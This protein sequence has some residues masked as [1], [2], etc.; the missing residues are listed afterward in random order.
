MSIFDLHR[1]AIEEYKNFIRS[2]VDVKDPRIKEYLRKKLEED[3]W[4]WPEP[5]LQV[6]SG[7]AYDKDVDGLARDGILSETTAR[8]FRNSR[9]EPFRLYRHQVEAIQ[10]ARQGRSFILTSG[11]GS[12]KSFAY[13]IPIF[14]Q[15]ARNP[16]LKGPVAIVVYPMN[17]LANSQLK[18][19]ETLKANYEA[20]YGPGSFPLSFALYTSA[21]SD[22]ERKRLQSDPPHLLLTNYVML[23]YLMVRP[24]D[25]PLVSPPEGGEPFFLVF[26][27]LHTYRGRQGAD[28]AILVRRL[29]ARFPEGRPLVHVGTS[30]TLV[31]DKK[32]GREERRRTVARFASDFFG[33]EIHGEDVVEEVLSPVTEGGPPGEDELRRSLQEPL[34]QSLS[35]WRKHPLAR[36]LEWELGLEE[37]DEGV[38]RRRTPRTIKEAAELLAERSGLPYDEVRKRLEEAIE[39]LCRLQDEGGR[40]VFAFKLHQ[41]ISQT[42]PIYATLEDPEDREFST[43]LFIRQERPLFPLRFCRNC[44]QEYY[45]ALFSPEGSQGGWLSPPLEETNVPNDEDEDERQIFYLAPARQDSEI[46]YPESW[47]D[48][49][50]KHGRE[51]R[52][53]K[54]TWRRKAPS[55]PGVGEREPVLRVWVSPSGR[56]SVD[57]SLETEEANAFF[58]Q[59]KPFSFCVSCGEYYEGKVSEYR[60]MTYLGSEGRASST[61]VLATALLKESRR[62]L[63]K[64]RSKLLSFTDNRQDASLQAGHF[65]D[66]A[67]SVLVRSALHRAVQKHG[68]LP[69]KQLVKE[70]LAELELSP[71]DYAKN[72]KVREDSPSLEKFKEALLSVL[73]LRLY[74]DLRHEWRFTQPNL[75]DLGLLEIEYFKNADYE[76]SLLEKFRA[77]F[78]RL[79]TLSD[80]AILKAARGFLDHLRKRLAIESKLLSPEGFKEARENSQEELNE[81]WAISE[82]EPFPR[83]GLLVLESAKGRNEKGAEPILL[84]QRSK[85][86]KLLMN[87]GL[88]PSEFPLFVE[89]LVE[90]D[91]LR[92]VGGGYRIPESSLFWKK[93]SASGGG[94]FFVDLYSSNTSDLKDLE[95]REHTAQ[96]S[97]EERLLRERRFR[98]TPEDVKALGKARRLPF[99]V[100]SPTLELGVDIADLD[101]V[102]LRN[103]PPT[104]ANYAQRSGRA[105]RQGQPGLI[106]TFASS[107]NH[108]DRYFFSRQ[109]DMVAGAVRAPA[110][111]LANEALLITHIQAEWLA[112]TGLPLRDSIKLVL[113]TPDNAE[114]I[115]DS[116]LPLNADARGQVQL[117]EKDRSGLMNRLRRTFSRD[118]DRLEKDGFGETWMEGVVDGAPENFDRAFERWRT[119]YKAAAKEFVEAGRL[120]NQR[121]RS[122]EERDK[123]DERMKEALRQMDLLEQ[124]VG[125]DEGDFYPYRYLANEGFLPGYGFPTLPVSV[126]VHR[127]DGEYIQRPRHLAIGEMSP[128]S[129]LYH[130]GAKWVP[131]RL[132][133]TPGGLEARVSERYLCRS[134]G[135]LSDTSQ[136][137]CP[138]CQAELAPENRES[139]RLFEFTNVAARRGSRITVNE[140]ERT[141]V[142]QNIRMSFGFPEERKRYI[143]NASVRLSNGREFSLSYLPAT[144]V[145]FINQ[146]AYRREVQQG[147]FLIDL[148]TGRFLT[149]GEVNASTRAGRYDLYVKVVRNVLSIR[150]GNVLN[151]LDLEELY[152]FAYALKRGIEA[153][154]QLEES[155][156]GLE[157][158]GGGE[159]LHLL[160]VEESEGGLGVLRRLAEQPSLFAEVAKRALEVLHFN[161]A[162]EDLNTDCKR[163]CYECLLSY[164]NHRKAFYLNRHRVRGLLESLAKGSEAFVGGKEQDEANEKHFATLLKNCQSELEREFLR[165]LRENGYRLPKWAQYRISGLHTIADFFYEPNVLVYI[166]GPHHREDHQQKIDERQRRNLM[167]LGYRVVVFT[168]DKTSWAETARAKLA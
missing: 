118:R 53:L 115:I 39:S 119:L 30:A 116:D 144:E 123:A 35:A 166:D 72:P 85:L 158:L 81:T 49:Q 112:Y 21:T 109:Q 24:D 78:P 41:F 161:E 20:K 45:L 136:D 140:E 154:F 23:E 3:R 38:Y 55:I 52:K 70:V 88:S 16:G 10:R 67:Q 33:C 87:I 114:D 99:M 165:F 134:C 31:A 61:T 92:E 164:A 162:G 80:E 36:F 26:D 108:H 133:P 14:D 100:S 107:F 43:E 82:D 153:L 142:F 83:R 54:D 151:V 141:R 103:V 64:D 122:K 58:V 19:L 135:A 145:Y 139:L 125:K 65:N 37:E 51:G 117:S 121:N 143:Q 126:W 15:V 96:V 111:D 89:L 77:S 59:K 124:N 47:Y 86:G 50:D 18:A 94:K 22:G 159:K 8:V 102:H 132:L 17:A 11:T 91:L 32:A 167:G 147:G 127:G 128:G 148:E 146:G 105:G 97:V 46:A 9:G 84:S 95:A 130:E 79:A 71:E 101:M 75:E 90:V 138:H 155:E 106:L 160:Y 25:R 42:R 7:F 29:K 69:S 12:G 62:L 163:A 44:G 60:K 68:I 150:P 28:V 129:F 113:A 48:D 56:V 168:E 76:R 66:F 13:F 137:R 131:Y 27:E 6:S 156:L 34:P 73:E 149:E 104:P 2:F 74:Q 93:G 110:L 57:P 63:G 4:L 157:V 1:N 152:S 5:F 40:P 120:L 98:F